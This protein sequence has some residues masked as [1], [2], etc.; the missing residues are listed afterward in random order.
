M[1]TA[2]KIIFLIAGV[3][4][5]NWLFVILRQE[6]GDERMKHIARSAGF[7][8]WSLIV[9]WAG[10]KT[11]LQIVNVDFSPILSKSESI[12]IPSLLGVSITVYAVLFAYHYLRKS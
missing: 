12:N 9:I 1:V 3:L 7:G 4:L 2:I 8:T 10:A 5:L 11:L 6:K